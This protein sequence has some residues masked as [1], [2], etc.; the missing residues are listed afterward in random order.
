[1]EKTDV[2]A[3]QIPAQPIAAQR[4]APVRAALFA[5]RVYK[6]Y[7][8]L[9]FAGSCRFEP[10]CSRYAYEAIE[11]FGVKRG[12]WLAMKRLLRC[13]PLSGK[14]GYDPIP[15]TWEDMHS[16]KFAGSSQEQTR[17]CEPGTRS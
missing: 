17:G 3:Q 14:F 5:L 1:M 2:L 11:R 12:C 9:L 13:Q 7:F 15:E 8:S 16:T 6:S 4:A 10:T